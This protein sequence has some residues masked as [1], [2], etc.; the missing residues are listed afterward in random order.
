MKCP[1]CKSDLKITGK[2]SYCSKC[3]AKF[4]LGDDVD[5]L[6]KAMIKREQQK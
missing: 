3:G 6:L 5:C 1:E 2:E 4:V